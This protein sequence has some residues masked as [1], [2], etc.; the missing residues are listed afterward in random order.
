MGKAPHGEDKTSELNGRERKEG[1]TVAIRPRGREG[2]SIRAGIIPRGEQRWPARHRH[3]V[4]D[5]HDGDKPAWEEWLLA[6]NGAARG[7]KTSQVFAEETWRRK[8][9][10]P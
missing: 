7:G 6:G 10:K 4:T 5:K 8:R 3:E 9:W 1:G 2:E